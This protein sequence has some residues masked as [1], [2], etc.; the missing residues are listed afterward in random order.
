MLALMSVAAEA[1][2][3]TLVFDE[4]DAG[5]GGHTARAV[6]EQ[7][8]A[9]AEGRQVVC[10]TH[11]PQV[12]SLAA[13][14]FS[15]AK[16]TVRE[17]AITT[18]TQLGAKRSSASSSGCSA[19]RRRRG[20]AAACE[21][22]AQGGM[23]AVRRRAGAGARGMR[24]GRFAARSVA[25]REWRR[26][27]ARRRLASALT[28]ARG[29]GG[30]SGE[31]VN[32]APARIEVAPGSTA[33]YGVKAVAR[34][35]R[36]RRSALTAISRQRCTAGRPEAGVHAST[37]VSPSTPAAR[38]RG[39]SAACTAI[40][41][42]ALVARGRALARRHRRAAQRAPAGAAAGP[43]RLPGSAPPSLP[44][45][46]ALESMP[47]PHSYPL[48]SRPAMSDPTAALYV[49]LPHPAFDKLD[50]AAEALATQKALVT[51]LVSALRRPRLD[52]G[53]RP[54]AGDR[55][56]AA[57]RVTVDCPATRWPSA[58]TRSAGPV[59]DV[60]TPARRPAAA[61]RPRTR[62]S[63]SPRPARSPAAD[64]RSLALL[65]PGARRLARRP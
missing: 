20:G 24:R 56:A 18:V 43:P 7:L 16:D 10:I 21:G 49:R 40:Y 28:S 39:R 48:S 47:A 60:L 2:P 37:A 65:A 55:A 53:A 8:R 38:S 3:A 32:H 1:G 27:G 51:T 52:A 5:I 25:P 50:R 64:R 29:C 46:S 54:P 13:R 59:P 17:P 15:I 19:P 61:G 26:G 31:R 41:A 14:H 33:I 57:E 11:L 58:T 4:V 23:S 22:A 9:L 35:H 12:A 44:A 36:R 63:S 30:A 6:G 45:V 42:V 34:P 62:S